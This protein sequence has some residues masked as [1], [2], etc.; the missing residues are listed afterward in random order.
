MA[1]AD[2]VCDRVMQNFSPVLPKS[3][4]FLMPEN[5]LT[6]QTKALIMQVDTWHCRV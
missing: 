2:H 5:A 4:A 3:V 6:M 1:Q